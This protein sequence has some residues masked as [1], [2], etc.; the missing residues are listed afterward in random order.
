MR[1][2]EGLQNVKKRGKTKETVTV[3]DI[4]PLRIRVSV[5][6][7]GHGAG[8]CRILRVYVITM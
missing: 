7:G 5:A 4:F 1:N 3:V 6:R 8:W 2:E